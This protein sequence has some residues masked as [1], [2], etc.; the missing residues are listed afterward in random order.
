VVIH[1]TPEVDM[2]EAER[3][4]CHGVLAATHGKAGPSPT[5]SITE[6]QSLKN[7]WDADAA[8]SK[9]VLHPENI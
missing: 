8:V 7:Y 2:R 3:G 4:W 5:R 1:A 6:K 9:R